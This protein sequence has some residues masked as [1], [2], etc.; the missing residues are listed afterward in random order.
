MAT[1][2]ADVMIVD[3][4]RTFTVEDGAADV[5]LLV[6]GRISDDNGGGRNIT[7]SSPGTLKLTHTNNQFNSL[8][9]NAGTVQIT[10]F[11]AL[12]DNRFRLGQDTTCI[13]EYLGTGS[14]E[15]FNQRLEIGQNLAGKPG[16]ATILNNGTAAI[17]FSAGTFNQP[18]GNADQGRT[19]TLGGSSSGGDNVISGIIRDG[20]AASKVGVTKQG[21]NTWRLDGANTYTGDTKIEAGR[22]DIAMAAGGNVIVGDSG[23]ATETTLGGEA[24]VAGDLSFADTSGGTDAKLA[25]DAAT[26]G[27]LTVEGA[28]DTSAGVNVPISGIGIDAF[29][30]LDYDEGEANTI[31]PGDFSTSATGS[32]RGVGSFIDTGSVITFDLGYGGRTWNGVSDANW[33]EG[34]GS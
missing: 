17:T 9:V 34:A 8:W 22:L 21:S 33:N 31:D 26:A 12:G 20:S 25:V 4:H 10:T 3:G 18:L 2:A 24:T 13:L 7:K 15:S 23:L 19:L 28:T 16:G 1:V 11:G 6:S 29:T 14:D 32:E 5:D 30:V 27:A